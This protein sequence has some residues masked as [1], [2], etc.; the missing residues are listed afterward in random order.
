MPL[1]EV[2]VD[3]SEEQRMMDAYTPEKVARVMHDAALAGGMAGPTLGPGDRRIPWP[4]RLSRLW[5]VLSAYVERN[6]R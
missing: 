1:T 2:K 4:Q 6:A 3:R 5:D